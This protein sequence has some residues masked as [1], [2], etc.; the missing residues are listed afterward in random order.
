MQNLLNTPCGEYVRGP[1]E[2]DIIEAKAVPSK[3]GKV[4]FKAKLRDGAN[5]AFA[6]SFSR[7]FEHDQGKRVVFSGMGIRRGDDYNGTPQVTI[8]DKASWKAKGAASPS[9][10]GRPTP[11]PSNA[12]DGQVNAPSAAPKVI[13]G[14]TV[15][16]AINKGV[17]L[18]IAR[19]K[20]DMA[21]V[22]E[23]ASGLV[24][25]AQAMQAGKLFERHGE[26]PPSRT[27]EPEPSAQDDGEDVPF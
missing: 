16:M 11:A 2:A 12:R 27:P 18:A 9:D 17:D 22:Y 7:T 13:E 19:G 1:I 4:F 5:Y 21:T 25:M 8:G 20:P 14:V 3:T 23:L 24:R 10:E 26:A 15:G 6:T